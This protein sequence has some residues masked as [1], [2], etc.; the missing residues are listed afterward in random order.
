[1]I[2]GDGG[3]QKPASAEAVVVSAEELFSDQFSVISNQ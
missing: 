1:M 3:N 2:A